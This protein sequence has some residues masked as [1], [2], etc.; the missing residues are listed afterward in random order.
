MKAIYMLVC[1]A[2]L[3]ASLSG[4]A[5]ADDTA[6]AAAYKQKMHD[7]ATQMK[8][9]HPEMNHAARRK[10]CHKQLGPSPKSTTGAAAT[11]PASPAMPSTP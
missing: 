2:G 4:I 7:C 5:R 10:A 1:S 6:D 9:D 8:T 11:A 3:I